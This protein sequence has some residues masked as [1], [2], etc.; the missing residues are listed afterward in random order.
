MEILWPPWR[1]I[2][3]ERF[4]PLTKNTDRYL[5]LYGGRGSSKSDF[6]SKLLISRCLSHTYFKCILYRKN[7]NSISDS[8]YETIKQTIYDLG[9]E[10]LFILK[11]NPLEIICVLNGNKFIARGGDDPQKLKS[12]KDPTCVWYEEDIPEESDFATITLTV[13]SG[14]AELLQEIFTINPQVEGNPE[15]NWFWQRFFKDNKELSFRNETIV[16][17]ENKKISY[18]YTVHHSIYQDNRWL[19]DQVKAQIE[20]YKTKNTYLYSIYAK[21]L[22]TAKETGGN[23]YKEFNRSIH[24]GQTQYNKDISLHIT[25]DFNTT[26]Y[27]SCSIWQLIGN[28]AICIDEIAAKSPHNSPIGASKLFLEK[29]F[30]HKAGLYVYGDPAGRSEDGRT[31]RGENAFRLIS[32]ALEN[33]RPTL[34]IQ[35]KAPA[36][37]T[38]KDWI[39][40]IFKYEE[41]GM[42]ILI[43]DKCTHLISDLS[44]LKEAADGTKHKKKIRDSETDV[45][46][47]KYGHFSDGM[48]YLLTTAYAGNYEKFQSGGFSFIPKHGKNIR[49][50]I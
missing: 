16:E 49:K 40:A 44:Y 25:F 14:K 42:S 30:A 4:I 1:K 50:N 36:V 12:I 41:Q 21:G 27:I 23:F 45:P 43:S 31:E 18:Y 33:M 32:S 17:V 6:V 7:Y 46:Y 3:N 38:R 11:K 37:K 26:P 47:E 39:N 28:K 48:D 10:S 9:L 20:D 5:I 22:W 2:I 15:D 35:P 24:T 29:Y 34:R 13:R 19:S 8:S